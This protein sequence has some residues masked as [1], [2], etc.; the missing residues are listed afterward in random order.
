MDAEDLALDQAL[1]GPG[2]QGFLPLPCDCQV[3][4]DGPRK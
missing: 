2:G 4:E 3:R 1:D